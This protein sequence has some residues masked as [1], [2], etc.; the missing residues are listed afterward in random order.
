[1]TAQAITAITN[2]IVAAEIFFLAGIFFSRPQALFSASWFW[3]VSMFLMG[4]G[5]LIGGIDHGFVESQFPGVINPLT[6]IN[7]TIV[8]VMTF[9]AFAATARQFF[10]PSTGRILLGVAA[11]QLVIYV[12]VMFMNNDYSIVIINYAPVLVFLLICTVIGLKT[13]LGSWSMVLGIVISF[14]A[15]G[16]QAASVDIFSP[17]D[18]DGLYHVVL[19]AG[20]LFL[21]WG[22]YQFKTGL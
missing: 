7:W 10:N 20:V 17:L 11:V 14:I 8:G 12:I 1:M 18:H 15:S 22:G 16:L 6:R 13:G 19:F 3:A 9:T 4:A 5:M 21:Y 2:F